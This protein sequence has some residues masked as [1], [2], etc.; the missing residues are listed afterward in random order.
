MATR[1]LLRRDTAGNWISNNP[2]LLAGEIGIEVDTLKFKIGNGSRWND[3]NSY[4]FNYGQANGVASLNSIGK[5]DLSVLPGDVIVAA[6]LTE[7]LTNAIN[8]ITTSDIEEGSNRYF[9]NE[10]AISANT[11]ALAAVAAAAA[12][13]A[14]NKA[15]SAESSA[16]NTAAQDATTKV[17]DATAVLTNIIT[18]SIAAITTS[19]VPEGSNKYFTDA[20]AKTAVASDIATAISGVTLTGKTTNNLAEG[21][22]NLYFTPLRALQ[23]TANRHTEALIAFAT[24]DEELEAR[25][26]SSY[27]SNGSLDNRLGGYIE[28]SD[29]NQQSGFA[30]LDSNVKVLESVI[31]SSIAR[32]AAPQFTGNTLV[33]NLEVSGNLTF[34]GVA[35]TINSENLTVSDSI[36]YLADSQY[37][38]DLLDIGIYGAYGNP[39][40]GHFHTGLV[41]DHEDKKWKLFS[42]GSEPTDNHVDFTGVTYDTLKLGLIEASSATIGDVSNAEIQYLSGVTSGI[43]SQINSISSDISLKANLNSPQFTGAID[44]TGVAI[45]GLSTDSNLP[46]QIGNAGNYLVTDGSTATWQ[47]I[48]LSDYL[49]LTAA[50]ANYLNKDDASSTYLSQ[51]NAST[52]YST[53]SYSDATYLSQ[54]NATTTYLTKTDAA[55]TYQ[56][57]IA[58]GTSAT[59]TIAS[60]NPGD[61][62]IQY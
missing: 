35:T 28:E 37:N 6:E 13:D 47:P 46:P 34:T 58:Y 10:R 55:A 16:I 15:G 41:R 17:Q 62:Y 53:Q 51:V 7:A 31:P 24:G 38:S 39:S 5:I 23:A 18:S 11:A 29:R 4:A 50:A 44:F 56:N 43:Q 40:P 8:A 12:E 20:R 36:I 19:S 9:T 61:V 54:A 22:T 21:S 60:P 59:P 1:I 26:A 30:G 42:N 2:I 32:T 52:T 45:S 27:V 25:I 57:K 33:E 49:S 14:T 3:I 48:N